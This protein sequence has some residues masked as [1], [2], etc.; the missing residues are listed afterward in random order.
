MSNGLKLMTVNGMNIKQ[1]LLKDISALRVRFS[2]A[3]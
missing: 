1:T 2:L 3:R